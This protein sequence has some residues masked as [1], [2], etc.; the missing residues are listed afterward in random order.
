MKKYIIDTN[1]IISFVTERNPDQQAIVAP[2]FEAAARMKCTLICHQFVLTEF[3]FVMDRVYG[4]PKET[5]N[6]MIR[7]FIAMPGIVLH[8]QTDFSAVLSLWPATIT[9]FG[10]ALLAATAKAIKG[11][12]VVTFDQKFKSALKKLGL[13]PL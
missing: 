3:I 7:D 10:D 4:V 2:L 6:A 11:A 9:D 12:T 8:Q 5:V 1:A 13:E